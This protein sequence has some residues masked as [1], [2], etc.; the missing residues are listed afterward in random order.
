M[1][2][3]ENEKEEGEKIGWL[4]EFSKRSYRD[5]VDCA[6]LAFSPAISREPMAVRDFLTR[7]RRQYRTRR[8]LIDFQRKKRYCVS[9]SSGWHVARHL[10]KR[11]Y[12]LASDARHSLGT[13]VNPIPH[14]IPWLF[15]VQIETLTEG[16]NIPRPLQTVTRERSTYVPREFEIFRENGEDAVETWKH[17]GIKRSIS[18]ITPVTFTFR[19]SVRYRQCE[20]LDFPSCWTNQW[21]K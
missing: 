19:Y 7:R 2:T 10:S 12:A 16:I 8:R 17:R 4:R 21:I 3:D 15:V 20:K 6:R 14:A 11:K 5:R 18:R 13:R 9:S 1:L